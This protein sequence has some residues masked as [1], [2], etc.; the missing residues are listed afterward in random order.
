MKITV[1][2]FATLARHTPENADEFPVE[3]GAAVIT[4]VERLGMKP[5]DINL[6]FVN[7]AR[8]YLETELND[9]DRLG[10]FPAVGG[11]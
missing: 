1:K 5:E 4:I 2:C 11:G 7:S 10:L 6:I 3:D 8:A 9:G